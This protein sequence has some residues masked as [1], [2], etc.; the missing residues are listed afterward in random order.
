MKHLF[1]GIPTLGKSIRG[2]PNSFLEP[3][4]PTSPFGGGLNSDRTFHFSD[5]NKLVI[6]GGK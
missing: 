4:N 3:P 2:T 1:A 5:D 6:D